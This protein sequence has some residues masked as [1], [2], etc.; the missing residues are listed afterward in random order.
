MGKGPIRDCLAQGQMDIYFLSLSLAGATELKI[1]RF[2][3]CLASK[4]CSTILETSKVISAQE[5]QRG[6][7]PGLALPCSLSRS[8]GVTPKSEL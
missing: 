6:R 1:I 4:R 8:H 7:P 5:G 3:Q 2:V